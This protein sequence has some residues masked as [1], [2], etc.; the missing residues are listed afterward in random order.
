MLVTILTADEFYNDYS[1]I[2]KKFSYD[3]A[4]ALYEYIEEYALSSGEENFL[5]NPNDWA[6]EWTEYTTKEEA[7][8]DLGYS[9]WDELDE[10]HETHEFDGGVLVCDY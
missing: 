5:M 3:G 9:N 6:I 1:S 8:S 4:M 7:V 10:H 2:N